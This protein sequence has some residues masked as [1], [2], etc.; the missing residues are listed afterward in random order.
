[1]HGNKRCPQKQRS[2]KNSAR[3]THKMRHSSVRSA[4]QIQKVS[5][6]QRSTQFAPMLTTGQ[7]CHRRSSMTAKVKAQ[8]KMLVRRSPWHGVGAPPKACKFETFFSSS[9]FE[10]VCTYGDRICG[11]ELINKAAHS[12]KRSKQPRSYSGGPSRPILEHPLQ[13]T[14]GE[15]VFGPALKIAA[16]YANAYRP[17]V[18]TKLVSAG[19]D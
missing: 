4:S 16:S 6:L 7:A 17:N 8:S 10:N 2:I 14:L 1:M 15:E 9:R 12:R 18:C 11:I 3:T 5:A 19:P 13:R